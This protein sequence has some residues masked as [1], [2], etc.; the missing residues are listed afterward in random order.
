MAKDVTPST[1][2][3]QTEPPLSA[4]PYL[5]ATN[6]ASPMAPTN[7]MAPP[8]SQAANPLQQQ[9]AQLLAQLNDVKTP[10][11]IGLWPPAIG[12][13]IVAAILIAGA[14][15][16]TRAALRKYKNNRYRHQALQKLQ[17]LEQAESTPPAVSLT[18]TLQMLKQCMFTAYPGARLYVGGLH[19]QEFITLLELTCEKSHFQK[20]D[21]YI[22][23]ILYSPSP[24]IEHQQHS[25]LLQE[26]KTWIKNHKALDATRFKALLQ[27]QFG[28]KLTTSAEATATARN[29]ANNGGNFYASV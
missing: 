27:N 21:G 9:K 1:Q 10:D 18:H 14:V 13:W 23:R 26:A 8:G 20:F 19:G 5:P 25:A 29:G 6:A 17:Q 24:E 16:G 3:Q 7:A 4:A 15:T 11:N 12:W 2:E 22:S 28:E